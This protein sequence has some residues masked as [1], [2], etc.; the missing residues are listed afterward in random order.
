M[1]RLSAWLLV[2]FFLV[3]CMV[4]A[5]GRHF[6]INNSSPNYYTPNV[7]GEIPVGGD[8]IFIDADRQEGLIFNGLLGSDTLPIVIVNH[9]GRVF[10]H[11]DKHNSA[12]EFRNCKHI[13]LTG[14]G[15]SDHQY[16]FKLSA[17]NS[18]ISVNMQSSHIEI[19]H[20]EIDHQ[21]FFGIVVKDDYYGNPPVPTPVFE[22]LAIHNS[23]VQ[24]VVEG[25]YLGET[26]SPGMEFRHVRIY[27]NIVYNTGREGIQIANMVD[28][29][30][31]YNN[32]ILNS[33][34]SQEGGQGNNLQIGDN[35]IGNFYNNIVMNAHENGFIVFGSGDINI[36]NN[37]FA[38][39]R[40]A[41]I[42]NRKVTDA[43]AEIVVS[44]NYFSNITRDNVVVNYNELNPMR[45]VNNY[46]E[47][48]GKF[49]H[50]IAPRNPDLVVENNIAIQILPISLSDPANG[51]FSISGQIPDEY[52]GMGPQ[53]G[54]NHQFNCTPVFGHLGN[55]I[56]EAGADS[57]LLLT[58][59]TCDQDSIEFK[60]SAL[61][62]FAAIQPK[63]NGVIEI[64]LAPRAGDE[65][66]YN[67]LITASDFS[68][69][70]KSR[71][72]LTIAVRSRENRAP[73]LFFSE[74]IEVDANQRQLFPVLF[75][76]ADGDLVNISAQN[77]PPFVKL[78]D[79]GQAQYAV[80]VNP[81][82]ADIGFYSALRLTATDGFNDPVFVDFSLQVNAPDL[83]KGDVVYRVNCGG[84]PVDAQPIG[85]E[86]NYNMRLSYELSNNHSTGSH[87]W[88]GKNT[89]S[90]PSCIFGP[91]NYTLNND[92]M[93]WLFPC[94]N[95]EYTIN[96]YFAER[97][98]DILAAKES[99]FSIE[100]NGVL[101]LENFSIYKHAG[102][103]AL[104]KTFFTSV[105]EGFIAL[106]LLPVQNQIKLH[107]IE[108]KYA[109]LPGEQFNLPGNA[110]FHLFPNPVNDWFYI[111]PLKDML[112]GV[113]TFQL[114][115]IR[116]GLVQGFSMQATNP[117]HLRVT[118]NR[119]V[120]QNGLHLLRI[121]DE[122]GQSEVFKV[123]IY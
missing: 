27:N 79:Q 114:Y 61:P 78:I 23:L 54:L 57:T 29:V 59:Q 58:A 41:F 60:L 7:F 66:I 35:C 16:G 92:P 25:M 31:V 4:L 10:I 106:R 14:T 11:S 52:K 26:V 45:I 91:W 65:G 19:G 62:S 48:K 122:H 82:F 64:R 75:S 63:G 12:I 76:D 36:Y 5:Q 28:D 6:Y 13:K 34:L 68:H 18:G 2:L 53:P 42:D 103:N 84:P 74:S 118:I 55:V 110:A 93:H 69:N 87:G 108:I 39:N 32:L 85:W 17:I 89:T 101:E 51:D 22:K 105:N 97:E 88:T 113:Y 120:V 38:S 70:A 46:W 99:V 77:F 67:L 33:G 9:N 107:G 49:Y 115:N 30:E 109:R 72:Q 94:P 83:N 111:F 8:T 20:V 112:Q 98:Q 121:S 50:D 21:G 71:K 102:L 100:I 117:N 90:A 37:Y 47:G 73:K 96:L 80:E 43:L 15:S 24:N 81:R 119:T 1:V 44:N 86:G 104:K 56:I 123:M 40:G 116:G 95:G 3:P